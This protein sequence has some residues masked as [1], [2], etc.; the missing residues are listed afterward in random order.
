MTVTGND[1]LKAS[2]RAEA[3]LLVCRLIS[4]WNQERR[5]IEEIRSNSLN[6]DLMTRDPAYVHDNLNGTPSSL[7]I[8]DLRRLL[9]LIRQGF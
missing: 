9:G 7:M 1:Y 6:E 4:D 3:D 8:Y 5:L 2:R